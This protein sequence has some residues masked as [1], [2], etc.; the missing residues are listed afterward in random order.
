MNAVYFLLL[1]GA[2]ATVGS[3]LVYVRQRTPRS[4]ESGIDTFR[5]EME[6][7][8]SSTDEPDGALGGL[9]GPGAHLGRH[10]SGRHYPGRRHSHRSYPLRHDLGGHDPS[11]EP[12]DAGRHAA[13]RL[14]SGQHDDRGR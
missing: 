14:Y 9:G 1:A 4:M 12:H 6:A 10:F 2:I 7:L 3:T 5:R 13:Q 11:P 8:A